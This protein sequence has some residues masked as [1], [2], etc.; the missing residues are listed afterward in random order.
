[1]PMTFASNRQKAS[2]KR[3]S[4]RYHCATVRI[5]SA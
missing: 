2:P 1:M 3:A 4:G 5:H